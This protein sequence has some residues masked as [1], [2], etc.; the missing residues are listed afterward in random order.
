MFRFIG[1]YSTRKRHTVP[2]SDS[3]TILTILV[4]VTNEGENLLFSQWCSQLTLAFDPTS[5]LPC[6]TDKHTVT[7]DFTKKFQVAT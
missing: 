1:T 6:F 7:K 2:E 4:E 3:S 5:P